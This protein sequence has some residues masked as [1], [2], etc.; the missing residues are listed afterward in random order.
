MP[1]H[2]RPDCQASCLELSEPKA[3]ETDFLPSLPTCFF[4]TSAGR[5]ESLPPPQPTVPREVSNM[6]K[7]TAPGLCITWEGRA[8]VGICI[9]QVPKR[10]C[11]V[12]GVEMPGFPQGLCSHSSYGIERGES[13]ESSRCPPANRSLVSSHLAL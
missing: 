2:H 13:S 4:I 6:D 7:N 5:L 1:W 3:N 12:S 11:R 8:G 9:F 10:I